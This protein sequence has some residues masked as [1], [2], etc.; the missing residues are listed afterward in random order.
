MVQEHGEKTRACRLANN[1]D[2]ACCKA[3]LDEFDDK[4]LGARA[5]PIVR[6]TNETAILLLTHLKDC[7]ALI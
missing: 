5:Y 4:F 3:I 6:Y 7:Y 1:V 2:K